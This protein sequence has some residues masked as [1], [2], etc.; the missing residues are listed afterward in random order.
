MGRRSNKSIFE[1][2]LI[3]LWDSTGC[4]WQAW[5]RKFL[6][7]L[8]KYSAKPMGQNDVFRGAVHDEPQS[9]RGTA[10]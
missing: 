5:F 9:R 4:I 10:I 8:K 7:L 1:E 6:T 3:Q 2:M